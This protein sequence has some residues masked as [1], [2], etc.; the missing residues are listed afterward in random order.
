MR[1]CVCVCA[2]TLHI[3]QVCVVE[4]RPKGHRDR[5]LP[6][7]GA[8]VCSGVSARDS[9]PEECAPTTTRETC[10]VT[11]TTRTRG[12]RLRARR[13]HH[14]CLASQ[15]GGEASPP[16]N[17]NKVGRWRRRR[18]RFHLSQGTASRAASATPQEVVAADLRRLTQAVVPAHTCAPAAAAPRRG[19]H[20]AD[21]RPPSEGVRGPRSEAGAALPQ[22]ASPA[23]SPSP[24]LCRRGLLRGG[25]RC[26][27]RCCCCCCRCCV[28]APT[29]RRAA[30]AASVL[31]PLRLLLFGT[32][33][34]P[35]EG[36]PLAVCSVPV[37]IFVC[38]LLGRWFIVVVQET[39][40]ERGGEGG[41]GR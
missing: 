24:H 8:S 30:A 27:C 9:R 21:L 7:A 2:R 35:F 17:S 28:A 10:C 39:E 25:R 14:P 5:G 29:L 1:A 3:P 33:T 18:R 22:P 13:C 11:A 32:R 19:W 15:C 6:P 26:C 4:Q 41:G 34:N 37:C 31:R 36:L 38:C 16:A 12:Q 20:A 40:V 23:S